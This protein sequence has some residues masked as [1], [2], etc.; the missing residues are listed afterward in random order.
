MSLPPRSFHAIQEI[1]IRWAA[2]PTDIVGWAIENL[3]AI[4]T[5]LPPVETTPG[6]RISG[7]AEIAGEDIYPLFR[8][9]GQAAPAVAITRVR[10]GGADD[11]EWISRPAEGVAIAAMDVLV[12]RAEVERFEHAHGLFAPAPAGEGAAQR[13]R[14]PGPGA[15][16]RYDWDAF[17]AA[18]ARRV[19]DYGIPETQAELTREMLNWFDGRDDTAPDESTIRRKVA[20]VWRELTRSPS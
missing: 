4:S 18:L 3:L 8:R 11:W 6:R 2:T 9:D 5:A 13:R 10:Q 15:P 1:A 7:L 20:V 14:A 12:A 17:Y 16:V 19:H